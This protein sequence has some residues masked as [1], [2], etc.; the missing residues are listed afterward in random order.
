MEYPLQE[1]GEINFC[2][3]GGSEYFNVDGGTNGN[4]G[5]QEIL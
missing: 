4:G 1:D 5:F 3:G 2:P